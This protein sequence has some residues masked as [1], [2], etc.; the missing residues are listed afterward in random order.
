MR[1]HVFAVLI[2]FLYGPLHPV[3][4]Q[5]NKAAVDDYDNTTIVGELGLT[6]TNF[7]IIGEGWNNPNQASCRYKQYGT[8]REM[9]ELMSYGGLWVGGIPIVNGEAGHA[10]VS[11]AIIDGALDFGESGFEFIAS[12]SA[13]DTIRTHSS[14]SSA[15]TSPL[16]S[17]FS[18]DAVSQQDLV[19]DFSDFQFPVIRDTVTGDTLYV[20][21]PDEHLP[22]GIEVHLESYAWSYSFLESIV[23]LDYTITNRSDKVFESNGGWDI[24]NLHSGL[25]ADAS[26]NN[27]NHDDGAYSPGW[28]GWW[29]NINSFERSYNTNGYP[30]NF[31][32]QFDYDGDDGW[33]RAYF[34]IM[35][36]HGPNIRSTSFNDNEG[37]WFTYYDQW[38][39][40]DNNRLIPE[41]DMPADDTV[42]YTKLSSSIFFDDEFRETYRDSKPWLDLPDSWMMLVSAGPFGTLPDD[43]GFV[44]PVG[45]SVDV[46]F[47]VFGALWSHQ[48]SHDDLDRRADLIKN[49]DWAQKA[50]NGEDVNGNSILDAGEDFDGDGILDRYIVPEPPP[51]PDL[52]VVA[53]DQRVALYWNNFPE[54]AIDPVSRKHD[55]AGYRI[56]GS[57]KTE[58]NE[59]QYSLLAEFD[60]I[61]DEF[62][63]DTGFDLV[64]IKNELGLP[65]PIEI[66]GLDYHY[67]WINAG[68]QNGWPGKTTYSITAYDS[69]DEATGLESLESSRNENRIDVI[70]GTPPSTDSKQAP[71]SV[72][73]NPYRV[74]AKWDGSGQRDRLVWFRNLPSSSIIR[75]Y[76][77]SGD[78]VESINHEGSSYSGGDIS[79]LPGG[80]T[81]LSGGEHPWDLITKYDEAVATGMYVYT[82][83]DLSNNK[84]QTGKLLVIK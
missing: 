1:L 60:L 21:Y 6:V 44:L 23:F 33:S 26:V 2:F 36:L 65:E 73:P 45:E 38:Q 46:V 28:G 15:G 83:E 30:R 25:W 31:G 77:L 12:P 41:F 8:E 40:K 32:Y 84:V 17:Y 74:H 10:R 62:G 19:A 43:D 35:N 72:Y 18:L 52:T 82:V 69:G 66:N 47:A 16:A 14:I 7:G 48:G 4:A 68:V 80:K 75:I 67:K 78:L 57:S 34:A 61:G 13:G 56:Y 55:F 51:S 37:D 58:G 3:F 5:L 20:D 70:P 39:W 9:I 63:Y 27:M 81:V 50:F 24:K 59:T 49:A 42:R 71:V 22:L 11:T 76:T 54:A 53:D 79:R 64:E 29:D